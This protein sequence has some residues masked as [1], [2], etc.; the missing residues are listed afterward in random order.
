MPIRIAAVIVECED[1]ARATTFWSRA[2]RY[3]VASATPTWVVLEESSREEVAVA[4]ELR[5]K[6]TPP[7]RLA[8]RM[9]TP[10]LDAEVKRLTELGAAFV[11]FLW[12]ADA[13]G[14]DES[15][16]YALLRD[17]EGNEFTVSTP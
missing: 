9:V 2:L 12:L 14:H 8:L 3:E 6:G 1:I 13:Y 10:D 15:A 17:P 4:L 16:R 5:R 11:D 7:A